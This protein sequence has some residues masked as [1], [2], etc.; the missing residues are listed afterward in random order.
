MAFIKDADLYIKLETTATNRMISIMFYDRSTKQEVR[1]G[2]VQG[3]QY[4]VKTGEWV[5]SPPDMS[6]AL[7]VRHMVHQVLTDIQDLT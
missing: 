7:K 1:L 2:H 4:R 3:T 5:E 6:V